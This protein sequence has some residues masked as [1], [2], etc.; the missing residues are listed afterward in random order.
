M[1]LRETS[2]R[3]RKEVT[4]EWRKLQKVALYES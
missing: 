1:V 2:G 3:K 4:S